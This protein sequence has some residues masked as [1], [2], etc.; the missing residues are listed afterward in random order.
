MIL[1]K[2][3]KY[4]TVYTTK[5]FSIFDRVIG[6]RLPTTARAE[7]N[8]NR[9]MKSIKEK[10]IPLPILVNKQMK[11]VDGL[12][13]LEA[14]RR[15]EKPIRYIITNVD[16]DVKDIQRINNISNN[17]NTEDYL[18]S[19]M[20][21]EKTNFP[22]TFDTK[23]Y[24]MYSLFKEKYKFS[25]R[26][27]LM[28]LLDVPSVPKELEEEFKQGKFKILDWM[29]ACDT[30]EYITG[31]KSYLAD[32]KN[33]NFVTAFLQVFKH[34]RFSKRTWNK[35]LAQNSRKIVHCTNAADYREVIL[36]VYNWG[37]QERSRLKVKEAA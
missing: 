2:L 22:N 32:Y 14:H 30:A 15:L 29:D 5:D 25:H 20:D 16:V 24:H 28:M 10:Y 13:R 27:N 18:N 4:N 11:V 1:S 34:W 37:L 6:N 7:S 36:E 26:N 23:P 17:W 9:I 19:N 8:I 3:E 12:H 21:V 31:F 33:R 35:K